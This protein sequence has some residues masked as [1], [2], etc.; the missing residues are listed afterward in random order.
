[1]TFESGRQDRIAEAIAAEYGKRCVV[2]VKHGDTFSVAG[3]PDIYGCVE[4]K[5]F[6]F[7]VKSPTGKLKKIQEYRLKNF[8][9]AGAI[10]GG[11]RTP[12][13]ALYLIRDALVHVRPI[14]HHF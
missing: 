8:G 14:T 4:G 5:M 7:E 6:A 12:E 11:I 13:E 1:M 10:I 3:D 2:R 9:D